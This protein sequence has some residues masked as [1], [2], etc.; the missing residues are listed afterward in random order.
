MKKPEMLAKRSCSSR[1]YNIVEELKSKEHQ[2]YVRRLSKLYSDLYIFVAV[3]YKIAWFVVCRRYV[4]HI[5][6]ESIAG[7][8]FSCLFF[9]MDNIGDKHLSKNNI[10]FSHTCL[11][12]FQSLVRIVFL[13][14]VSIYSYVKA[15][16]QLFV[17]SFCNFHNNKSNSLP[18]LNLT[19][20]SI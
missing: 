12:F 16:L 6:K 13:F 8:L 19:S 15:I 10:F 3:S 11:L 20:E 5:V 14:S 7:L 18:Q 2:W 1:A 17:W 9:E 4:I